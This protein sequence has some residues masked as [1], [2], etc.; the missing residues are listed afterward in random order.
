MNFQV[1]SAEQFK[2]DAKLPSTL[3]AYQ[4]WS[5]SDV[6]FEFIIIIKITS[7]K[8]KS[9]SFFLFLQKKHSRNFKIEFNFF[10]KFKYVCGNYYCYVNG[11]KYFMQ[12]TFYEIF[13]L[14]QTLYTTCN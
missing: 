13:F 10:F 14:K 1:A 7:C 3:I 8:F 2:I 5:S 11:F 4:K 12:M 6:T 9:T